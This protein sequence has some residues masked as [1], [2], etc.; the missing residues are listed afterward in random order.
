M[1]LP[2]FST[3]TG[4]LLQTFREES[5]WT[6]QQLADAVHI[7]IEELEAIEMG[8]FLLDPDLAATMADAL[9]IDRQMLVAWAEDDFRR[10]TVPLAE[11]A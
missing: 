11:A 3:P 10:L 4:W 9:H 2:P 6:R 1:T 8:Y 5:G 7:S